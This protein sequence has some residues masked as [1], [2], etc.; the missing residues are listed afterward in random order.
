M[1]RRSGLKEYRK[2]RLAR[3]REHRQRI[4][5]IHECRVM[6]EGVQSCECLMMTRYLRQQGDSSAVVFLLI[7]SGVG[8]L[9]PP[10]ES[11]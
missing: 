7:I 11:Y 10:A 3:T 1:D 6:L 5:L 4:V 8:H 9:Y 2:R